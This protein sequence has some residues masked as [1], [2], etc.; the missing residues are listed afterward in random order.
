MQIL[1]WCVFASQ[2]VACIA[3]QFCFIACECVF[4]LVYMMFSELIY[5]K[6]LIVSHLLFITPF[7]TWKYKH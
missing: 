5:D 2:N 1:F 3:M 4:P 7:K 6:L